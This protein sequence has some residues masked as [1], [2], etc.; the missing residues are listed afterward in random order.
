MRVL[1][2]AHLFPAEPR[3]QGLSNKLANCSTIAPASCSA[4]MIV[5][6]RL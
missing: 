1:H 5:T 2:R 3:A 6:A 4:S